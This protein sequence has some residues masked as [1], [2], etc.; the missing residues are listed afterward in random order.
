MTNNNEISIGEAGVFLGLFG[1]LMLFAGAFFGI[2]GVLILLFSVIVVYWVGKFKELF[3]R[4]KTK[5]V[6]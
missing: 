4:K 1:F 5:K 3:E 2:S 6:R